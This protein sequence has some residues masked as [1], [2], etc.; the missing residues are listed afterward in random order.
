MRI[1]IQSNVWFHDLHLNDL[2]KVLREIAAAGYEGAEI[3]A[4]K[5]NLDQP[6]AFNAMA[7]QMGLVVSGIHTHG[8]IYSLP[9]IQT[10]S[11]Y[12][13]KAAGFANATGASCML[14]SG[15]RKEHKREADLEAEVHSL[16]H[17]AHICQ[18]VGLPLYYHSHNWELADD[19]RELRYLFAH[20][21]PQLMSLALD[22]GWVQRAGLDPVAVINEFYGR[23]RYLHF[24]DSANDRWTELGRG[25]VDFPAVLRLL[26][27]Q[28]YT[29]W[30]A[31]ER[32]EEL[33]NAF[34]SAQESRA[35]L[36]KLGL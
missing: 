3:G 24:K 30:L 11:G 10:A 33:P 23:I 19:L 14:I 17:V 8:E 1:A 6:A 27:A 5:L 18:A 25:Q 12:F 36:K 22:I 13:E 32:D 28:G 4:H 31:V 21:D 2:P 20:T 34:E 26:E 35:Y 7:A 16:M 15:R 9:A 29:G